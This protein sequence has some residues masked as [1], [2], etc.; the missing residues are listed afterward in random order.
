MFQV[1]V[2]AAERTDLAPVIIGGVVAV[3]VALCT[4][5]GVVITQLV[6]RRNNTDSVAQQAAEAAEARRIAL[7]AE[8]NRRLDEHMKEQDDK[9]T[10]LDS[11]V[12]LLRRQLQAVGRVL[13][14]VSRDY[15]EPSG[16]PIARTDVELLQDILPPAWVRKGSGV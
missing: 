3:I 14:A 10:G 15:H 16:P 1:A 5:A 2:I 8:L 6:G 7:D 9:I 4:L 13:H 12:G 11:A